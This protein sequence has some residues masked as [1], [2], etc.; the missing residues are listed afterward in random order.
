[1]PA[2]GAGSVDA[3][4]AKTVMRQPMRNGL[5]RPSIHVGFAVASIFEI[6]LAVSHQL[7]LVL[8]GLLFVG[9][10]LEM[11]PL[12]LVVGGVPT[13][14]RVNTFEL[15]PR[16]YFVG[17]IQEVDAWGQRV[18]LPLDEVPVLYFI[19]GVRLALLPSWASVLQ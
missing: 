5:A 7:A 3:Q 11:P 6:L 16:L 13:A 9:H 8:K 15:A 2:V 19:S 12:S 17:Q 10:I 18:L 14:L 1:M 4:T